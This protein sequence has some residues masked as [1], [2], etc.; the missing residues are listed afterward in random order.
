MKT[1]QQQPTRD[2]SEST[3]VV[4]WRCEQLLGS[5]FDA[6]LAQQLAGQCGIDLHA[7]IE[8]V[9]RG[10]PPLLAARIYAPLEDAPFLC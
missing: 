1:I 2:K 7:L 6:E 3:P 9:E 10:C 4:A 5:G 8:L